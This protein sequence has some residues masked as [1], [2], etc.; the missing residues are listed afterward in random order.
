MELHCGCSKRSEHTICLIKA[1]PI[2][3]TSKSRLRVTTEVKGSSVRKSVH[4]LWRAQEI[5]CKHRCLAYQQHQRR[6]ISNTASQ[7]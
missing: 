3:G 7:N 1:T 6:V 2:V 4:R 5:V